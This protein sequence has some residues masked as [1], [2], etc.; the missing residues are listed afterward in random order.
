MFFQS[1]KIS[2]SAYEVAKGIAMGKSLDT[3]AMDVG[4][5]VLSQDP[6]QKMRKIFS[7]WVVVIIFFSL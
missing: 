3:N 6:R 7:P 4:T 5:Y 1:D 2:V